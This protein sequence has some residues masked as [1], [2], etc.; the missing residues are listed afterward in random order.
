MI[1]FGAFP[2]IELLKKRNAYVS[3]DTPFRAWCR[4][5]QSIHLG[6]MNCDCGEGGYPK[7]R[8]G[9]Y[10]LPADAQAGRNFLD[11]ETFHLAKYRLG[12]REPGDRIEEQRLLANML[13][14]QTL[15]FNLFLPQK[16]NLLAATAVWKAIMPKSVRI[17]ADVLLEHSPARG[18]RTMGIGD[19]SAF[20]AA[21]FYVHQDGQHGVVA[22]ETKYTESFSSEKYKVTERQKKMALRK[23]LFTEYGWKDAQKMPTQ[24]LWRTHLLA[25]SMRDRGYKHVTY[26]VLHAQG[27]QECVNLSKEYHLLLRPEVTQEGRFQV[28][29]LENFVGSAMDALSTDSSRWLARFHDRYLGWSRVE[30]AIG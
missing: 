6:D 4:L 22:V 30:Q 21:V 25:E 9:N 13:T 11:E 15:C 3:G 19:N 27:D 12:H 14:S 7:R 1:N 16:K 2:P 5:K 24:Q 18:S 28:M 20:D 17:V 10:L 23:G 29:T 26:L 8:L